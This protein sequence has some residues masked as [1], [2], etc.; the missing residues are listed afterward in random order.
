MAFGPLQTEITNDYGTA[1]LV[2]GVVTTLIPGTAAENL[3]KAEDAGHSN[4]D[5]GVMALAVRNDTQTSL[6]NVTGDYIPLT[7]DAEGGLWIAGSQTEDAI[8]FT[9]D[10]G[11]VVF[12]VRRDSLGTSLATSDG[13]YEP[14]LFD[15]VGRLWVNGST[16]NQPVT[17]TVAISSITTSVTPGTAAANL[18]KAEDAPH[19]TGDVGAMALTVRADVPT[20]TATNGN[21]A[22]LLTDPSGALWVNSST[23]KIN[24]PVI[25]GVFALVNENILLMGADTTMRERLLFNHATATLYLKYG[26][27]ATESDYTIAIPPKSYFEFPTPIYTGRVD[28]RWVTASGWAQVTQISD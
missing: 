12:G 11:V 21:Y 15:S 1:V 16:V 20:A 9:G 3:G 6:A 22:A 18:G 4:G 10:R 8:H 13:D 19:T 14:H 23:S 17:G 25:S 7:T 28:G 5:V 26:S 27:V 2:S 24:T